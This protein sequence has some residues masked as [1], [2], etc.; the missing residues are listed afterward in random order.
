MRMSAEEHLILHGGKH[1]F[2]TEFKISLFSSRVSWIHWIAGISL[3]NTIIALFGKRP[4][5]GSGLGLTRLLT[6]RI[7]ADTSQALLVQGQNMLVICGLFVLGY[8]AYRMNWKALL[9]AWAVILVDTV[10]VVVAFDQLNLN[11]NGSIAILLRAWALGS[12]GLAI[13]QLHAFRKQS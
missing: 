4:I 1:A 3:V 11:Q 10:L 7:Q 5:F 2:K 6:A 9:T 8:F 13:L 12:I